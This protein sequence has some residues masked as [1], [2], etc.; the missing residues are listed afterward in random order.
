VRNPRHARELVI[1]QV[2]FESGHRVFDSSP[3]EPPEDGEIALGQGLKLLAVSVAALALG[4][5]PAA[6]SVAIL[7][8]WTVP[9][10]FGAG[11]GLAIAAFIKVGAVTWGLAAA[12]RAPRPAGLTPGIHL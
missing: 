11:A 1:V 6:V 5:L 2:A 10:E 12:G 8:G 3:E 9:L 7:V 4:L